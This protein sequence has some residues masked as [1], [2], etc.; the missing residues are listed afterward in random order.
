MVLPF[1]S[2]LRDDPVLAKELQKLQSVHSRYESNKLS[3]KDKDE[4]IKSREAQP[5]GN[6]EG[7]PWREK[8]KSVRNR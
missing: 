6:C 1:L 5:S 3:K 8:G 7:A 4:A 2:K